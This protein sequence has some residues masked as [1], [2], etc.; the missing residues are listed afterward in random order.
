[1]RDLMTVQLEKI[2]NQVFKSDRKIRYVG[3]LSETG[4]LIAGGMRKGVSSLEPMSEDL[5]LMANLTIQLSTDKTWDR[6]F[7]NTQFTF[8]KR[9]KVSIIVFHIGDKVF[10]IST[11]PDFPLQQAQ[12]VRDAVVTSWSQSVQQNRYGA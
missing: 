1:M 7:G 6:Y 2:C 12:A 9:E 10:L 3:I 8:I 11:E 5:R 4:R